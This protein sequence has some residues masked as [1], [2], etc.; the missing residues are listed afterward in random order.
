MPDS[1]PLTVAIGHCCRGIGSEAALQRV[2]E[3]RLLIDQV[4]LWLYEEIAPFLGPR[5]LEVGCGLG[6]FARYMTDR[7]LYVGVDNSPESVEHVAATFRAY[8]NMRAQPADVS[9]ASFLALARF[10]LDTVVSLN[11]LE[12]VRD[13]VAAVCHIAQVLSQAGRLVLVVPAHDALYG[14]MDHAIGHYR[15]YS[16]TTMRTLFAQVG[17]SVLKLQ[18]INAVGAL[19]WYVN[20]RLRRQ[21]T[22][23]AGQLQVFNKLVPLLKRL[24]R[25]VPV[26]FGISLVAIGQK[27]F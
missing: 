15:R 5:V 9:D 24:E 18:Y 14:T 19:G 23:P 26:P 27:N 22:P 13:D 7:E 1:D 21:S 11:T 6:N 16:K 2:R 17:L 12:H 8:P 10:D 3:D 20:G 4:D 25:T